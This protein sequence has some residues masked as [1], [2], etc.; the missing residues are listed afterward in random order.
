M[1]ARYMHTLP[2]ST[3]V[4]PGLSLAAYRHFVRNCKFG[5]FSTRNKS[6]LQSALPTFTDVNCLHSL[7]LRLTLVR[8]SGARACG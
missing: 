2:Y 6:D 5:L 3:Y 4:T 8:V 1:S 7:P